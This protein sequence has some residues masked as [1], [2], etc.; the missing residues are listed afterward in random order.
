MAPPWLD[1]LDETI[2]ACAARGRRD[3]VRLLEDRRTRLLD[4]RLRVL[5]VGTRKRGPR[6][7]PRDHPSRAG[8]P[9]PRRPL[10]PAGAGGP[11]QDR[12]VA[13]L[14]PYRAAQP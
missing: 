3:L 11:D 14:A 10:L 13:G 5:V 2:H 7:P 4:P 12:P 1:V 9:R 8:L 6:P